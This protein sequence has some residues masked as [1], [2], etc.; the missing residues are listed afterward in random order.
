MGDKLIQRSGALKATM[1]V[2]GTLAI[3][4]GLLQLSAGM[5]KLQ[6]VVM[7]RAAK[8]PWEVIPWGIL[9]LLLGA[10]LLWRVFAKAT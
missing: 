7:I 5:A 8:I 9:S 1:V 2:L 10:V 6:Y 3:I 4:S